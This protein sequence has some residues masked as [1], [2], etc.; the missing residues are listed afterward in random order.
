MKAIFDAIRAAKELR[1][2]DAGY[3]LRE[4]ESANRGH[5]HLLDE[6][7]L[8]ATTRPRNWFNPDPQHRARLSRLEES[9]TSLLDSLTRY[10]PDSTVA[11]PEW[12]A[13]LDAPDSTQFLARRFNAI[14]ERWSWLD[15]VRQH[16]QYR[17]GSLHA[18]LKDGTLEL[19]LELSAGKRGELKAQRT[20]QLHGHRLDTLRGYLRAFKSATLAISALLKDPA[21]FPEFSA[22]VQQSFFEGELRRKFAQLM[23][24][25]FDTQEQTWLRERLSGIA[26]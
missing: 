12:D 9:T 5:S 21:N 4:F 23:K 11:A 17:L 3:S 14:L 16:G 20:L 24:S 10:L 15:L 18:L 19:K 22:E 6:L 1:Q 8:E 13:I 26:F 2:T 25:S 7:A